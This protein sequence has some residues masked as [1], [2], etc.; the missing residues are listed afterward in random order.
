VPNI[1]ILFL[2]LES[3]KKSFT[4]HVFLVILTLGAEKFD[5]NLSQIFALWR[6]DFLNTCGQFS[7]EAG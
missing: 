1:F 6:S 3:G 2:G 4:Q 5:L 7:S